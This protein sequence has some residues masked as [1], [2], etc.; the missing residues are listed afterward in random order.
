MKTTTDQRRE[1]EE[2]VKSSAASYAA[3]KGA[4]ATAKAMAAV[5][6]GARFVPTVSR[7]GGVKTSVETKGNIGVVVGGL[8]LNFTAT[9]TAVV[10]TCNG[11]AAPM[12][13]VGDMISCWNNPFGIQLGPVC[14]VTLGIGVDAT[15]LVAGPTAF[16]YFDIQGGLFLGNRSTTKW[17]MKV[18]IDKSN[19]RNSALRGTPNGT[20]CLAEILDYPLALA[21]TAG[22][23]VPLIPAYFVPKTCGT[24]IVLKASA[25]SVVI[26]GDKYDAGIQISGKITLL[27]TTFSLLASVRV[28]LIELNITASATNTVFGPLTIG[29]PGCD[30]I[31]NTADDGPC[32]DAMLQASGQG[33]LPFT[34]YYK[35]NG[36]FSV[37]NF[38]STSSDLILD[39]NG[40]V[41]KFSTQLVFAVA[42][43]EVS[44]AQR[45]DD[46][47]QGQRIDFAVKFEYTN[48]GRAYLANNMTA[49]LKKWQTDMN[50]AVAKANTDLA[51][52][53]VRAGAN[54][55]KIAEEAT[56]YVQLA[57]LSEAQRDEI[58]SQRIMASVQRI[59]V[60]AG[61]KHCPKTDG[62][63]DDNCVDVAHIHLERLAELIK[64]AE[65]N[66]HF[67]QPT[68]PKAPTAPEMP[69]F[70]ALARPSRRLL[71]EVK[72]D[73]VVVTEMTAADAKTV[74]NA[75]QTGANR[76][77]V[78][79]APSRTPSRSE[80]V[81]SSVTRAPSGLTWNAASASLC[82]SGQAYMDSLVRATVVGIM[83]VGK[84]VVVTGGKVVPVGL[85]TIGAA[86]DN[87]FAVQRIYYNGSLADAAK[88]NFGRLE[89]DAT[90][91]ST[92]VR[93][94]RSSACIHPALGPSLG[95]R[96]AQKRFVLPSRL[97]DAA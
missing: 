80:V 12:R 1:S 24:D 78:T 25:T 36:L 46:T 26:A 66:G 55:R 6:I 73:D 94:A 47:S 14:D 76:H 9:T 7:C 4:T 90:T 81:S 50:T 97:S 95:S 17:A 61:F 89:I 59:A 8:Q 84:T 87:V 21:Q 45:G 20:V 64:I 67:K 88:G 34:V 93:Y 2:R 28:S 72:A 58:V 29:G 5:R 16:D 10:Q 60:S 48:A 15:R 49:R 32:L 38:F 19:P 18:V 52:A 43:F 35:F 69:A 57:T 65:Q 53:A 79:L 62:R 27:S 23:S 83:N 31:A 39:Q 70:M 77:S 96:L 74:V 71:A 63:K 42:N 85:A 22:A 41:L 75:L 37:A 82:S 30:R 92:A 51:A 68:M 40:L 56:A 13:I 91:C 86:T 54:C 33:L 11:F 44:T 3:T